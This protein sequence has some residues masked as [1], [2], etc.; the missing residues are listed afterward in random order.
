MQT[1]YDPPV[2]IIPDILP[3]GL[4]FFNSRPKLGKSYFTL[5]ICQAVADGLPILGKQVQAGRA[6]YIAIEDNERRLQDRMKQQ[7]WTEEATKRVTFF[8]G[9]T[10]RKFIGALH[11]TGLEK[12]RTLVKLE[13]YNFVGIDT[14]DHAFQD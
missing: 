11:T 3:D 8:T 12:L 2:C 7:G 6:L 14:F 4:T 9:D 10:F 1:V 5:Q 13:G